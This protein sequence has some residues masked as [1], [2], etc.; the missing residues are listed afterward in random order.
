MLGVHTELLTRKSLLEPFN[1]LILNQF[2]LICLVWRKEK[3]GVG[4]IVG[5]YNEKTNELLIKHFNPEHNRPKY[6]LSNVF[7]KTQK[8]KK[9]KS[10]LAIPV[11]SEYGILFN[12]C[13]RFNRN[14][15]EKTLP[16]KSGDMCKK[17]KP[18]N[19]HNFTLS[20]V[21]QNICYLCYSINGEDHTQES[22]CDFCCRLADDIDLFA[23]T[24]L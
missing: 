10:R 3:G 22:S 9:Q 19:Y 23:Y 24:I 15:H 4:G 2:A 17:E 20:S 7:I 11:Y 21:L 8:C 14:L 16:H 5:A 6:V 18:G 13:D 1:V 12:L